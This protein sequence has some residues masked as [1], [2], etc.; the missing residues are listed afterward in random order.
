MLLDLHS[1]I[2]ICIV[3]FP[4]RSRV[5]LSSPRSVRPIHSFIQIQSASHS[6]AQ[7]NQEEPSAAPTYMYIRAQACVRACM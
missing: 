3:F 6:L 7:I 1:G 4:S 2:R 5:F